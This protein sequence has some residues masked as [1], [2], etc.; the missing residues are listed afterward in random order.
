MI[1]DKLTTKEQSLALYERGLRRESEFVHFTNSRIAGD[2]FWTIGYKEE[3]VDHGIYL[4]ENNSYNAY[5]LSEL[6]DMLPKGTKLI[7]EDTVFL[8]EVPNVW[9]LEDYNSIT[10]VVNMLIW[11]NDQGIIDLKKL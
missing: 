6:M 9:Q 7:K 2:A 3:L 8:C 11:L 4:G 10:A 5:L 1:S